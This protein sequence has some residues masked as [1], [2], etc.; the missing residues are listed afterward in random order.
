MKSYII[1][2]LDGTLLNTIAD[3]ANAVNYALTK[4]G[5]PTHALSSYNLMVGNGAAKLVERALPDDARSDEIIAKT[6][7]IFKEYYTEH[8]F[9]ETVPYP[10]IPELLEMLTAKGIN[11]AV[12]SNKYQEAVTK[13]IRH[14]FPSANFRSI[15]GNTEGMPRKPDPSILFQALIE[16]PT[17]KKDV[18]YVGDSGVDMETARRACVESV[19]VT[20]GFRPEAELK[21]AY[22]DHI[23]TSP[24][25]IIKLI[26][27]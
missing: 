20:W 22:A 4:L 16:C 21:A 8:C 15:L 7:S 24:L 5:Y 6:L 25:Q 13:I 17:P 10:E 2:D 11:L 12:T 14:Y 18:L 26:P 9:D 27:L 19:G 3:L 23:V 1:F